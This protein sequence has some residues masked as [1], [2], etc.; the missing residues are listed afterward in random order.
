MARA[1][2]FIFDKQTFLRT[3]SMAKLIGY[4]LANE[5]GQNIQGDETCPVDCASFEVFSFE[6]AHN[7]IEK[8]AAMDLEGKY[9]LQPIYEG[10]IEEHQMI[11][12]FDDENPDADAEFVV[13]IGSEGEEITPI[14]CPNSFDKDE[15]VTAAE[16]RGEFCVVH[17][18]KT[19][20]YTTL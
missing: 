5:D 16:N 1:P 13:L 8:L 9:M 15:A 19:P 14:Y 12:H 4:Q 11:D 3:I 18:L 17:S 6:A 10:D 2:F 7:V 20:A